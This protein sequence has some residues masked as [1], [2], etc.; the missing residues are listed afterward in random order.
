MNRGHCDG[1]SCPAAKETVPSQWSG[2]RNSAGLGGMGVGWRE[3]GG[4][5]EGTASHSERAAPGTLNQGVS[6]PV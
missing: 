4:R 1:I 6:M 5:R 3:G 2:G